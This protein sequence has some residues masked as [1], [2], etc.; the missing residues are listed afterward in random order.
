MMRRLMVAV[1]RAEDILIA[2]CTTLKVKVVLVVDGTDMECG[3]FDDAR[4]AGDW[5]V[6]KVSEYR[7]HT[8]YSR[9]RFR[10]E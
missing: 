2:A 9:L 5:M 4:Q 10:P 3:T 6:M 7:V 1:S 8:P